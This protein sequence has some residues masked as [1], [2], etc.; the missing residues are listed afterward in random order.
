[1]SFPTLSQAAA[2]FSRHGRTMVGPTTLRMSNSLVKCAPKAWRSSAI[3]HAGLEEG[4]EDFGFHHVPLA[5]GGGGEQVEFGGQE[6]DGVD[7]GRGRR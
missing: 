7:V 2:I 3:V 1:L 4:A 6:F 5:V